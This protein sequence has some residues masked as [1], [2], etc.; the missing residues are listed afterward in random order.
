MKGYNY[1]QLILIIIT[2]NIILQTLN[3][4]KYVLHLAENGPHEKLN[5]TKPLI[6]SKLKTL[7]IWNICS[8]YDVDWP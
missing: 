5:R 3:L 4:G 2:E 1:I 8:V 6:S 7:N